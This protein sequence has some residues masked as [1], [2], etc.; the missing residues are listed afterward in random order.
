MVFLFIFKKPFPNPAQEEVET[1]FS[2][3][4]RALNTNKTDTNASLGGEG[5][6]RVNAAS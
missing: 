1:V 3:F 4:S 2:S 5:R 6:A